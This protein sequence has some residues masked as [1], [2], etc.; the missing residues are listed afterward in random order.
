[1]KV[2]AAATY[3]GKRPRVD[4]Q[5]LMIYDAVAMTANTE[6]LGHNIMTD[7]KS[8]Q[9]FAA[10]ANQHRGGLGV[11]GRFG[12]PGASENSAGRK[13]MV[14]KNFRV[15]GDK[16]LHDI[17]LLK[18]NTSN[19]SFGGADVNK[20]LLDMAEQEPQ[21]IAESAV[22]DVDLVWRLAGGEEVPY[23]GESLSAQTIESNRPLDA[24]SR[25]PLMRPTT[26]YYLDIV[27]EG[28]LTHAGLFSN[29]VARQMFANTS[30]AFAQQLF[31]LVD[32]W[33]TEYNVPLAALPAKVEMMVSR[34][35]RARG[36]AT[37]AATAK[38]T[39]GKRVATER[40]VRAAV[41]GDEDEE[42]KEDD[43]TPDEEA[44]KPG[45]AV[46]DDDDGDEGG[47]DLDAAE[48]DVGEAENNV[49]ERATV[50]A[51]A[52]APLMADP[53]E[54]RLAV[55]EADNQRMKRLL[56]R[57]ARTVNAQSGEIARID[58]E[59]TIKLGVGKFRQRNPVQMQA[60][61]PSK[62]LK[63]NP[64]AERAAQQRA[65]TPSAREMS[66][67]QARAVLE[68]NARRQQ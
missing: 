11:Q 12:H 41:P 45:D 5:N 52:A 13:V 61:P 10:L 38:V 8:L 56:A 44:T 66:D 14:T 15:V 16:L 34:Y 17:R 50:I 26:V 6:A 19:P 54:Q 35:M 3:W 48:Q 30:N 29:D 49:S 24:T 42:L 7:L 1:M 9:L 68:A 59:P 46:D 57:L 63:Q 4:R 53:V 31:D 55:L 64:E 2:R 22:V 62:L 58:G 40:R 67:D 43:L 27:N 32:E 33:R 28:A 37:V 47:D 20:Y 51:Q 23:E 36:E 39:K 65:H 60:A 18:P 21:E 25:L